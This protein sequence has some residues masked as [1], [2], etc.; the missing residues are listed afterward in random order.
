MQVC[1]NSLLQEEQHNYC[2]HHWEPPKPIE[3]REGESRG[4]RNQYDLSADWCEKLDPLLP[5]FEDFLGWHPGPQG[6]V[7]ASESDDEQERLI[8]TAFLK[9]ADLT[10][11]QFLRSH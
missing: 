11:E 4:L 1:T 6:E 8:M 3:L 10:Q 2:L 7:S 9:S 5:S